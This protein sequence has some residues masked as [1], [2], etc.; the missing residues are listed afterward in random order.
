METETGREKENRSSIKEFL[1]LGFPGNQDVQITLCVVFTVTYI[2]T[3]AG[4]VAIIA[5]VGAHSHLQTP[6]Y[7]FL[8]NLS[9]LEI[10]Y[11]TACV[12]KAIAVFLG[13]SRIIP[14]ASCILQTY[15]VFSLGCTEFLLLTV[16]AYDR[17]LAICYPLHYSTIMNNT[18]SALLAL[19][20]WISGFLIVSIPTSI[21]GRLFYCDS[22]TINHFFCS[23]DSLILLS[24][25]DTSLFQWL[26]FIMATT[27]ILGS[28]LITLVSYICII[29]TIVNIPSAKGRQKAFSTCSAHLTVVIMWYGS[30]IFLYIKYSKDNALE[31]NKIVNTLSTIITPLLNP[32]IYTLRNKDVKE[33]LWKVL[34]GSGSWF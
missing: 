34:R 29:T 23:I 27:V 7:F 19:V 13:K 18:K 5:V 16:M 8:S 33:A 12:P 10:W 22:F 9:F 26:T 17:Y 1:L 32:F 30:N 14:F 3:V 20:S 11:T 24:C 28:L 25:S 21:L 6:M 15:F 4:N 2:L 31:I